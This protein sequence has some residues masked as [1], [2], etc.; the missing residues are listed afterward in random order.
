MSSQSMRLPL[1]LAGFIVSGI[2][3]AAEA[4]HLDVQV[5]SVSDKLATGFGDFDGDSYTV[6]ARVFSRLF[7]SLFAVNDPGF[8]AIGTTTGTLPPDSNALPGN[9]DL[10]WDFLPMK[11]DGIASNLLY[12]DGNGTTADDVLFGPAPA[13]TY[14]LSLFGKD[15]AQAAADGSDQ[16]ISGQIIDKTA[17]DGF[18]HKH[19]YFFLDDD[20]DPNNSTVAE[21]GVYL[22]AMRLRM[23]GLDQSDPF[24]LVWGTPTPVST[25]ASSVDAAFDWVQDSLD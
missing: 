10:Y 14:S 3:A 22:I 12:W 24:F 25:I 23:A 8:N 1:V 6:G 17:P 5:Q 2:V 7:N 20:T 4:Q 9:T 19:R 11:V 13:S 16:L 21:E 15:D 18:L